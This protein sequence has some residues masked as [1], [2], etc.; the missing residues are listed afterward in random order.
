MENNN[1]HNRS[2]DTNDGVAFATTDV[3]ANNGKGNIKKI[4]CYKCKKQW[5][6]ANECK[7]DIEQGETEKTSNK[8]GSIFINKGQFDKVEEGD[9][10]GNTTDKDAE[11]FDDEYR[12]DFLQHDIFCSIQD[13]AI[14]PKTWILLDSKSTIDVVS[15]AKLLTTIC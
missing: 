10:K 8:K 1:K 4:T 6:Y 7:I 11:N 13:K 2:L 12:F 3:P 14:I 15:N 5:H 9:T